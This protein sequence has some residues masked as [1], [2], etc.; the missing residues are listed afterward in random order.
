M[1]AII[2]IGMEKTGSSSIQTWLRANRAALEAEGVYPNEGV[3]VLDRI[4]RLALKH[5][6]YQVAKDEM[7]VDDKT[8][9]V[10]PRKRDPHWAGKMFENVKL[11]SNQLEEYSKMS[12][13]F[14]YSLEVIYRCHEIQMIAL[15]KYLSRYFEDR[16]YVVYIRNTVDFFLSMYVQKL[17]NNIFFECGTL[18][19]SEFLNRCTSGLVPYGLES[20]FENLFVWKRILKDKFNV[21]LLESDWLVEGDLINDFASL[22]GVSTFCKPGRINESFAAE[23]IEY[24]RLVNLEYKDTLPQ[25]IRRK[26]LKC[27]TDASSGKP[28]LNISDALA[29]SIRELHRDQ[30]ERIRRQFFPERP[31]LYSIKFHG[32]EISPAPLSERR[33]VEIGSMIQKQIAPE[34]WLPHKLAC[35]GKRI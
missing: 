14:V 12:G 3:G 9:W 20:S 29:E 26:A 13:T 27:L 24:V 19:Y 28:K 34:E 35:M 25:L 1:K 6:I 21:R 22:V 33:K 11:L 7:G 15:E 2:H 5:A 32:Q 23:Y 8:A 31:S 4:R 10:G 30:E 17:R 16:T 18:E